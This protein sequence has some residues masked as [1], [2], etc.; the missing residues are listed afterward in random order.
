MIRKSP[1][2]TSRS[3]VT[4]TSASAATAAPAPV[5]APMTPPAAIGPKSRL[6]WVTVKRRPAN[7]QNWTPSTVP[8]SAL[9]V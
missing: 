4:G 9:H 3:E 7:I 2:E 1:A 5:T 6:P 8:W